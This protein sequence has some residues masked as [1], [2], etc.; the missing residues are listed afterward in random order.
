MRLRLTPPGTLIFLASLALAATA[1]IAP[2]MHIPVA[3]HFVLK[4]R[5]WVMTAAYGALLAGVIF[6]GL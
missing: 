3:G 4:H 5:F 1:L 6:A 2:H